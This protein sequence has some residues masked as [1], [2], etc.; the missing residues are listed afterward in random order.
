LGLK[1]ISINLNDHSYKI[2]I[3]IGLLDN[4]GEY[5][6]EAGLDGRTMV[7]T[8]R[9]VGSLYGKKLTADLRGAGLETAL[10]QVPVGERSKSLARLRWLYDQALD[11]G[12]DRTGQVVALGGGVVGDLAG[13]FASTYL[14]GVRLIQL[15]TTLLAQVDSSVG[16]KT[17]V[18]LPRGKN[19]VG[20]FHQPELVLI[21]PA[22]LNSLSPRHYRAG[23]AEVAKYGFIGDLGLV[24][25]LESGISEIERR[26]PD[27]LEECISLSCD[28]K[29][30]IVESDEKESGVRT[31]LNYG[32]TLGHAV[33]VASKFELLH[34]EAVSLGIAA[35][36]ALA[37]DLGFQPQR[38]R[39]T[40][41]LKRLGLPVRY[42]KLA[43]EPIMENLRYD[44]KALA[45][46]P[47]FVLTS[48]LG[49]AELVNEVPEDLIRKAILSITGD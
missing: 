48:S 22:T 41:L 47:R 23:W 38:Q 15:P 35:A 42:S 7:I 26:H 31:H 17:A 40:D 16:G 12:F 39:Q 11:W 34:G 29:R 13:F 14:R 8:D 21:D 37:E 19:L 20:S 18:N 1:Q 25:L 46:R 6:R 10:F 44:K 24:E 9:R 43:P 3:K 32:H 30:R 33:E 49:S 28:H 45:G 2:I 5:L 27:L 4:V 36:A